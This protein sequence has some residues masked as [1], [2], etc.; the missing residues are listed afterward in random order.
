LDEKGAWRSPKTTTQ[1]VPHRKTYLYVEIDH[2][3]PHKY[4]R[5]FALVERHIFAALHSGQSHLLKHEEACH[6]QR[7]PARTQSCDTD[8]QHQQ[9]SQR[10]YQSQTDG[11]GLVGG[12]AAVHAATE[13]NKQST[14]ERTM[15]ILQ[16]TK[17][18][19]DAVGRIKPVRTDPFCW[20]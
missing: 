14:Q 1:R 13:E 9:R 16:H 2:V 12:I 6:E 20:K 3:D 18:R 17:R 8:A 5:R 19:S 7:Q 11:I 15:S 10:G 4:L